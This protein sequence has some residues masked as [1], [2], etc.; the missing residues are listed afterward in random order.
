MNV[1]VVT[2][3]LP[4]SSAGDPLVET[5]T[6]YPFWMLIE[7]TL[8]AELIVQALL[9]PPMLLTSKKTASAGWG[10]RPPQLDQF[11]DVLK[12]PPEAPIQTQELPANADPCITKTSA[13]ATDAPTKQRASQRWP[14]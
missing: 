11:V 10:A 3:M 12:L 13:T 8:T 4:T 2:V 6:V 1:P 5:P 9:V 14:P 7:A